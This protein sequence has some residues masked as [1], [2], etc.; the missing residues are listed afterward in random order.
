M[1]QP[2][3][4]EVLAALE[5]KDKIEAI[6]LL[7]AKTNLGLAEA[8]AAVETGSYAIATA[9]PPAQT[10]AELPAAAVAALRAGDKIGAIKL[11]RQSAGVDLKDAKEIV[12]RF[13]VRSAGASGLAPGEVP[14]S[15]PIPNWLLLAV[16]IGALAV[17]LVFGKG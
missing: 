14:R 13:E 15:G 5:R 8:K 12:D 11:V 6:R 2:L 10:D 1:R 16:V 3:P 17:W 7:R 4:P 9:E